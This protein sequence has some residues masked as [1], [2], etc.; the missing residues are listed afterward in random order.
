MRQRCRSAVTVYRAA[1]AVTL[2]AASLLPACD[3]TSITADPEPI[4][5]SGG[6]ASSAPNKSAEPSSDTASGIDYA[7]L[8]TKRLRSIG[9][10]DNDIQDCFYRNRYDPSTFDCNE[11]PSTLQLLVKSLV[12]DIDDAQTPGSPKYLGQSPQQVMETRTAALCLRYCC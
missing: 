9:R 4:A 2:I 7:R 3:G 5:P 1:L 8:I 6:T 11:A 12:D 10:A